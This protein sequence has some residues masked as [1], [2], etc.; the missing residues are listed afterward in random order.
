MSLSHL[1][2]SSTKCRPYYSHLL[3]LL[4]I[5]NSP[6]DREKPSASREEGKQRHQ[7][8]LLLLHHHHHRRWRTTR[9]N[10][11]WKRKPTATT[12]TAT[13]IDGPPPH[14]NA[15]KKT[16]DGE[17]GSACRLK[18]V[19]SPCRS[20][21][22]TVTKN[23]P[24]E[25]SPMWWMSLGIHREEEALMLKMRTTKKK[26]KNQSGN[27]SCEENLSNF[28]ETQKRTRFFCDLRGDRDS[29]TRDWRRRVLACAR[30]KASH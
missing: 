6:S 7:R 19:W 18:I 11:N 1:L 13:Q 25:M 3:L 17:N 10:P 20:F 30:K 29:S 24:R 5:A 23:S 2:F 22:R 27:L 12:S 28:R 8:T 21:A 26:K 9:K 15:S 16:R 14:Q 4:F